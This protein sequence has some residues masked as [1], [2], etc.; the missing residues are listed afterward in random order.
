MDESYL[1]STDGSYY[2]TSTSDP[3]AAAAAL[4]VIMAILLPIIIISYVVHAL[5][6]GMIFKKAGQPAWQAWVPFLNVWKT[7]EIGDQKGWLSLLYLIPFVNLV[8]VVIQYIAMYKIGL[9]LQKEGWFV[10]LAIFIPTVWLI[11]LAVDKSTWEGANA[12][13]SAASTTETPSAEPV[14]EKTDDTAPPTPPQNL[15]Q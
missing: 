4:A 9:K 3:A 2:Y 10:L 12:P 6:L 11:W 15:V 14:A 13:V 8:A 5:F 1:Y 7:F